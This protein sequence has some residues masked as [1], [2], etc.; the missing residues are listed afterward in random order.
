MELTS[1]EAKK[2]TIKTN[3]Q[4]RVHSVTCPYQSFQKISGHC[5]SPW[6]K[7]LFAFLFECCDF[8]LKAHQNAPTFPQHQNTHESDPLNNS[9]KQTACVLSIRTARFPSD[10]FKTEN[11]SSVTTNIQPEDESDLLSNKSLQQ[12]LGFCCS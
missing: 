12:E 10:C 4:S 7:F 9:A 5:S 11:Y 8:I 3:K 1:E 2:I 6:G